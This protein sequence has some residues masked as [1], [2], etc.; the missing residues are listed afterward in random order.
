M[1]MNSPPESWD[2]ILQWTWTTGHTEFVPYEKEGYLWYYTLGTWGEEHI[3]WLPLS[4]NRFDIFNSYKRVA[5]NPHY[6][7]CGPKVPPLS[8]VIKKI[9]QMEARFKERTC[10]A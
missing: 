2:D 9:R 6:N 7:F 4:E 1:I 8:P 10:H 3:K 5:A